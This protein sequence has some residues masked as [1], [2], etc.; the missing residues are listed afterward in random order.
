[1][2]SRVICGAL[3]EMPSISSLSKAWCWW[4]V[5]LTEG[6][7]SFSYT[8][9]SRN[10]KLVIRPRFLLLQVGN[11]DVIKDIQ[12]TLGIGYINYGSNWQSESKYFHR[13]IFE[14]KNRY[15]LLHLCRF[16]TRFPL[17]SAKKRDVFSIWKQMV[18]L[19]ITGSAWPEMHSLALKLSHRTGTK[20]RSKQ[21]IAKLLSFQNENT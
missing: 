2:R 17:R 20:G 19:S 13:C 14:V 4:F 5:G 10:K 8:I 9:F 1:M 15:G 7:G 21:A 3:P 11:F 18:E 6:E 16:F 12:K